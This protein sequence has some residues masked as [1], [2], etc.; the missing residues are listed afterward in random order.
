MPPWRPSG[1][2]ITWAT[3]A[4]VP[5]G[6]VEPVPGR[7]GQPCKAGRQNEFSI[8]SCLP[9]LQGKRS[10][11][12]R[13][14]ETDSLERLNQCSVG[15]PG[16]APQKNRVYSRRA[17]VSKSDSERRAEKSTERW[18]LHTSLDTH[19]GLYPSPIRGTSQTRPVRTGRPG[20]THRC[21]QQHTQ[22]PNL[23]LSPPPSAAAATPMTATPMRL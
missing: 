11:E 5:S 23:L 15:C 18:G 2:I 3:P 22:Q 21:R 13:L 1:G 19:L 6:T 17:E 7:D 9:V 12:E 10:I 4:R 20:L 16:L 14:R 8:R